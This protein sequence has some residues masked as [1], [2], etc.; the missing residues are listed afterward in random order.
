[1]Q[2]QFKDLSVPDIHQVYYCDSDL[3]CKSSG[4]SH[5]MKLTLC[6]NHNQDDIVINMIKCLIEEN[7]DEIN[8]KNNIGRTALM[9]ASCN[10]AY[11]SSNLI[12]ELLLN[13]NAMVN[14]QDNAR[15]TALML[16]ASTTNTS[17]NIETL[18]L[19]INANANINICDCNGWTPLMSAVLSS[20]TNSNV[21]T[22]NTLIKYNADINYAN[23]SGFTALMYAT[24]Y[25]GISSN[26][27]TV[28][29]LLDY[30]ADVNLKDNIGRTALIYYL[31]N[32]GNHLIDKSILEILILKSKISITTQDYN[33]LSAYQYYLYKK[34]DVLDD[35]F[36]KL[37]KGEISM[38]NVK[39]AR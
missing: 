7:P 3:I 18:K 1:M 27:E 10:S 11:V 28:K 21:E 25:T 16:V 26:L 22:V 17:S 13:A 32:Y 23:N 6:N 19:L 5:L 12:V 30:G 37:L 34:Y 31:L 24:A 35:Y 20:N 14:L 9:L 29:M 4:F 38:S 2:N 15:Q 33:N 39:S 36:M 8:K